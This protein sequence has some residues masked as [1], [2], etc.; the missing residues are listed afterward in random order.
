MQLL[1]M[2]A[3]LTLD[4]MRVAVGDLTAALL[5]HRAISDSQW[6]RA[7]STLLTA[8]EQHGGR[9]RHLIHVILNIGSSDAPAGALPDALSELHCHLALADDPPPRRRAEPTPRRPRRRRP[10]PHTQLSLFAPD[11]DDAAGDHLGR[12]R[13]E[14][15]S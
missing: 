10:S 1:M 14:D 4:D 12:R 13:C 6:D 9:I 15:Q 5:Q 8:R 3:P 7:I 2:D 11:S